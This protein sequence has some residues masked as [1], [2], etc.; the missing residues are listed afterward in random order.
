MNTDALNASW[1]DLRNDLQAVARDA[2]ALLKATAD[3]GG[4]RIEELR[5]RTRETLRRAYD[6]LYER[7][8]QMQKFARGT[9][10]Y[11]RDHSW[12]AVA[13]AAGVG[14]LIGAAL[15]R[16]GSGRPSTPLD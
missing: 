13:V 6:H 16:T 2:E 14:L 4:E 8:L 1:T 3:V 7:N 9:D 12:S 15:A 5:G 11:I 10:S